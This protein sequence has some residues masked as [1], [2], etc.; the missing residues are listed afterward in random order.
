VESMERLGGEEIGEQVSPTRVALASSIGATIEWYDFFIYGTA[1][2]LVFGQLFFTNLPPTIGTIVAFATFAVGYLARPV[3]SVVFG[4]YGDRIGRKTMLILTLFIMGVATFAIGLLPT[5]DQIGGWAAVLLVTMRVLQGIAVGGEYGGAVL[6][7]VEY[8]PPGRRGFFGSW[9]QVGAPAGLLLASG[10]F[11]LLSLMP[12]DQFLAW[13]W[14]VA[15]LASIALVAVGLYI[16]LQ[17]LETPAFRRVRESQEE[18]RIPFVELLRTQ[19]K[20]LVLGMG[21]RWAEGLLFNVYGVFAVSYIVNQVGLSQVSVLAAITVGAAI[22]AVSVPFYGRL[23]DRFGRKPVYGAG[24]AAFGLFAAPS[25]LLINTGETVLVWLGILV[26][27][28]LIYPAVY[29]PLAAFWSELFDT[30]LRYPG[31]GAVYQFSGI[32]ASGL[33]PLIGASLVAY[34]GGSPWLFVGYIIVVVLI[35]LTALYFAPETYRRDIDPAAEKEP[36]P[37]PAVGG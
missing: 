24:A 17:I 5:Y 31:V 29:A 10:V 32:F 30:R 27:I 9:P 33:T 21:V 16:R 4:H 37:S 7:A 28:G 36:S 13:G 19:P 25:F 18:A 22:A 8:A 35:S 20:E 23:S 14:R 1:A 12:E 26:A 11:G 15:F 34:A 3:G 2:G 6:M